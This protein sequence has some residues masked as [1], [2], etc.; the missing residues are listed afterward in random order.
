MLHQLHFLP[1][2]LVLDL[3]DRAAMLID[4]APMDTHTPGS[5]RVVEMVVP[6]KDAVVAD[7]ALDELGL[8]EALS[9]MHVAREIHVH[10][11]SLE[12]ALHML[13]FVRPEVVKDTALVIHGPW[14]ESER[15]LPP[16]ATRFQV[17]PGPIYY[18]D[19]ALY[20]NPKTQGERVG[21]KI[22]L[23]PFAAELL[24][25]AC[26]P[27]PIQCPK[28][29]AQGSLEGGQGLQPDTVVVVMGAGL[30]EELRQVVSQEIARLNDGLRYELI[31]ESKHEP[32][33]RT[34]I[35]RFTQLAVFGNRGDHA[36]FEAAAQKI[37]IVV[38]Q[39]VDDE[40][41]GEERDDAP[42]LSQ[43]IYEPDPKSVAEK[44]Q[45][46]LQVCSAQWRL[47][48][49]APIETDTIR[50]WVFARSIAA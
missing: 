27:I 10:G 33:D 20:M 41:D 28:D 4:S 48:N 39:V 15:E 30:S 9:A 49:P 2:S 11:L 34:K 12:L 1:R 47:A 8:P 43:V 45:E 16:D 23:D 46:L 7:M 38:L 21:Q 50:G 35:R 3:R 26:G 22:W 5:V 19:A 6:S 44:F 17:W 36:L 24:P 14:H 29:E 42:P 25:R 31:D 13:P 37:P 18:D 32:R 40:P